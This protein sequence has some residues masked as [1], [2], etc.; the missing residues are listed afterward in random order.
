MRKKTKLVLLF[1]SLLINISN[2]QVF[3]TDDFK[4]EITINDGIVNGKYVSWYPNGVKRSEGSFR[5]N[6]RINIW[7]IWDSLG[8]VRMVRDY[9]NLFLYKTL[10]AENVEGDN[11][12]I[13][14]DNIFIK[15]TSFDTLKLNEEGYYPF[16]K[17]SPKDILVSKRIWRFVDS[18]FER[19][20]F[21]FDDNKMFNLIV[22][23]IELNKL[24]AYDSDMFVN[25][26][27]AKDI[28]KK[29]DSIKFNVVSYKI[30]EDW[31]FD[32]VRNIS[33]TRI[34]ALC[35]VIRIKETKIEQDLIWI[36]YPDFRKILATEKIVVRENN[37]S[38]IN[39]LDDIF[40]F[41][42]FNSRI[43]KF[44]NEIIES[45][46]FLKNNNLDYLT[47]YLIEKE[48]DAWLSITE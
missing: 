39:T 32:T 44:D 26:I 5:D 1:I 19:N 8:R 48:H 37:N 27:D 21:L 33:E 23:N 2:A 3:K 6:Q 31:F 40:M 25:K 43:Y 13:N 15:D 41:R 22:K 10:K 9:Q 46:N 4:Y 11:N 28:K 36:Y 47:V 17:L 34:I 7:T 42:F 12:L 24:L 14:V 18:N 38:A 20:H 35:P 29:L 16:Y 45:N 30:K